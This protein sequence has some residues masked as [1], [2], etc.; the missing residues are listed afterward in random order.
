MIQLIAGLRS[1]FL[2]NNPTV[3]SVDV[4]MVLGLA[5]IIDVFIYLGLSKFT[6][7]LNP[8]IKEDNRRLQS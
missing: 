8:K 7:L 4:V 2:S 5:V 3:T 1:I 6:T